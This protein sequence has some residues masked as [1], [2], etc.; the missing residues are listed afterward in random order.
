MISI[1]IFLGTKT[2]IALKAEASDKWKYRK[3]KILIYWLLQEVSFL[4]G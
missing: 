3:R 2:E 4:K 1:G